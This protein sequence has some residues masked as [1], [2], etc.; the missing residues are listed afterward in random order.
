[1]RCIR[2]LGST[3]GG[4]V[5]S[6]VP[7]SDRRPIPDGCHEIV[8]AASTF[9]NGKH[10]SDVVAPAVE[11]RS[12]FKL[13]ENRPE[14]C[15]LG[16]RAAVAAHIAARVDQRRAVAG[17]LE[18]EAL[19]RGKCHASACEVDDETLVVVCYALDRR[20][21]SRHHVHHIGLPAPATVGAAERARL[22]ARIDPA[23]PIHGDVVR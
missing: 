3:S 21:G 14:R 4:P 15:G 8:C 18:E 2:P 11:Q 16:L 13:R 22:R 6:G 23:I 19:V 7:R 17:G 1:M 10:E 12:P 20:A 5:A 9:G